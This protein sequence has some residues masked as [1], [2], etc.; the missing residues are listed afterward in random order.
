M[1]KK[2][3]DRIKRKMKDDYIDSAL[4]S[5]PEGEYKDGYL[6]GYSDAFETLGDE[7]ERE[8]EQKT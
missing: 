8:H 7:L 2:L 3:I 5:I 4:K 6:M 1:S